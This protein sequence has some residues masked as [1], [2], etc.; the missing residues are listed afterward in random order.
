MQLIEDI[1]TPIREVPDAFWDK[2]STLTDDFRR[3][4]V[5]RA[6]DTQ[7]QPLCID[8]ALD[9]ARKVV[10]AKDMSV[11][12]NGDLRPD[13]IVPDSRPGSLQE[14]KNFIAD[15]LRANGANT[16]TLTRD[17][18]LKYSSHVAMK[19][20]AFMSGYVQRRG[21]PYPGV[22]AVLIAGKYAQTWI[23]L[24]NDHCN[25]FLFAFYGT[26][27]LLLW[28]PEYFSPDSFP[29]RKALNGI[30]FGYVNV[31]THASAA[32]V[33]NMA[34]GDMLFIPANWWHYN[35]MDKADITLGISI[36]VFENGSVESLI[37]GALMSVSES[38]RGVAASP[39]EL[40]NQ[41]IAWITPSDIPL[42]GAVVNTMSQMKE[43]LQTQILL[44]YTANGVIGIGEA[45]RK[46][47]TFTTKDLFIKRGDCPVF[48]LAAGAGAVMLICIGRMLRITNGPELKGLIDLLVCGR[49]FSVSQLTLNSVARD[50]AMSVM[51][52]LFSR[53]VV[54]I[55][56]CS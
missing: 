39:L 24:H 31:S 50:E 43:S 13:A 38:K 15:I 28:P 23:G 14:Y 52:W 12:I 6:V 17:Y 51:K 4:C 7:A 10:D 22:N 5:I 18:C 36:G 16:V 2:I 47:D 53:G 11:N 45:Y 25:T 37:N 34:A 35:Q 32:E 9:L 3:P 41:K 8:D 40:P 19:V 33:F 56:G 30:C 21:V 55:A 46:A 1:A 26:K 49:P 48:T 20:C 29:Q 44:R 54:E 42:P 27:R